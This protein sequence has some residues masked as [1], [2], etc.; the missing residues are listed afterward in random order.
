MG[1]AVALQ[2]SVDHPERLRAVVAVD[3]APLRPRPRQRAALEEMVAAV[4]SGDDETRRAFI[5]RALFL[6]SSPAELRRRVTDAMAAVPVHVAAAS[7]RGVLG[8][9]GV[10]AGA[11][12]AVPV[13]HLAAD[14]PVNPPHVFGGLL[15]HAVTGWTVG[16][17]H[18]NQLEVP[19]QVN[20]MIRA[21]HDH[22]VD[23]GP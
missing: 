15:P 16:A 18:F 12:C 21:F 5:E 2:L 6:P 17:G 9:D 10:D 1:G 3:P 11:R 13:L 22:Y 19:D 20:P 4:E 23:A 7:M 8:W 14:P